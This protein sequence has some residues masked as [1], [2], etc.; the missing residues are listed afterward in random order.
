MTS[1]STARS[2]KVADI[3]NENVQTRSLPKSREAEQAAPDAFTAISANP[4]YATMFQEGLSP[5]EKQ[6]EVAKLMTSTLEVHQDRARIKEYE[7]FREWLSAQSTTLAQQIIGLTDVNVMSELQGVITDMTGDLIE[8]ENEMK[9]ILEIIES[10]YALRTSGNIEDAYREIRAAKEREE[11]VAGEIRG[12]D[13]RIA[14]I[15]AEI[16]TIERRSRELAEQ[17]SF[18]GFGGTKQ[19]ARVAIAENN[20]AIAKLREEI[21]AKTA[22]K[23]EL[24]NEVG[25]ASKLGE[26]AIHR[27]RLRELLDL[28]DEGNRNR[29]I[30][31]RDKATKFVDTAQKRTGGLRGRF[32]DLN[33][34]VDRTQDMN[35]GMTRTYAILAEGL[36]DAEKVNSSMR[37]GLAKPV[38]GE[39]L[40]QKM[41]REEKL[42]TLDQHVEKVKR[43]EAETIAT[44]T[45]LSTQAVRIHT[46]KGAVTEQED[47]A[48]ILNTQGVAAT[49]D[50][51]ATVLTAVT[52]AALGEASAVAHDTLQ[53]MRDSTGEV[54]GRE[55]IRVAMG[56]E[57]LVDN[58]S[59]LASEADDMSQITQAAT[60]IVRNGIGDLTGRMQ[61]LREKADKLR[62]DLK[63]RNAVASE[64]NSDA[65][66][67][68]AAPAAAVSA[69]PFVNV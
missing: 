3:L 21:D 16:E 48:R 9:P 69:N 8:F 20:A 28:S 25:E 47:T 39:Q 5:E 7:E 11:Q 22:R 61:E 26:N 54:A 55:V 50:R 33:S 34:Q 13:F 53:S 38:E 52:G 63:D 60:G 35:T 10:V 44:Y 15:E 14:D 30:S 65:K 64:N 51:V 43:S 40:L 49:A 2:S 36:K 18:L 17:R 4:F 12:I 67:A 42:N 6:A 24:Q 31:L 46:M 66:P 32:S 29:M 58:L 68:A 56:I 27:D 1:A 41:S 19:S 57:K 59:V 45:D 62:G 23:T 37:D